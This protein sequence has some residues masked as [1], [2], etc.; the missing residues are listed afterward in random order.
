VNIKDLATLKNAYDRQKELRE[1][2]EHLKE[3]P[4]QVTEARNLVNSTNVDNNQ[5]IELMKA[6]SEMQ[7]NGLVIDD[8]P[9]EFKDYQTI[10]Q[11]KGKYAIRKQAWERMSDETRK[12]Y[13]EHSAPAIY[14]D[15]H[16]EPMSDTKLE[17]HL[18]A[19]MEDLS[20]NKDNYKPFYPPKKEE[21]T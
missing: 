5:K 6:V 12:T 8:I 18:Q 16:L 17:A 21:Q 19:V 2:Q 9:M 7:Q 15:K 1:F 14:D 10:S 4:M 11:E 3:N 13:L 20:V